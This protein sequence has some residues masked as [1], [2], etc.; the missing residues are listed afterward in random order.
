MRSVVFIASTALPYDRPAAKDGGP[1]RA[2]FDFRAPI[3]AL[4]DPIDPESLFMTEWWTS[5]TP[6]DA[7]FLHRHD[8]AAIPAHIWLAT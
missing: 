4:K 5:P 2:A 1:A 8:A 7:D 6:V 3:L